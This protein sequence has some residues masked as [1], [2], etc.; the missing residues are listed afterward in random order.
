MVC[1][2]LTTVFRWSFHVCLLSL[3]VTNCNFEM[4]SRSE[5]DNSEG[6]SQIPYGRVTDHG[7]HK[8]RELELQ[9]VILLEDGLAYREIHHVLDIKDLRWYRL[10]KRR[11]LQNFFN[12]IISLLLLMIFIE[13]PSSFSYSSDP[14]SPYSKPSVELSTK[15]G[16][17]FEL[18]FLIIIF[19]DFSLNVYFYRLHWGRKN[20]WIWAFSVIIIYSFVEVFVSY[21]GRY[22]L[23][24]RKVLRPFFMIRRST[25]V[26]KMLKSLVRSVS[27]M[28]SVLCKYDSIKIF[29]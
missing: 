10:Y 7:T 27:Q 24:Y 2:R 23:M 12:A 13:K 1:S 20:A 17:G 8:V 19:I 25:L 3:V 16:L 21:V 4:A 22:D 6:S 14:A 29:T 15:Q 11:F 18:F 5:S 9:A 28:L 26:K